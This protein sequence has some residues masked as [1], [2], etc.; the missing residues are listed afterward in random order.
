MTEL[1]TVRHASELALT[2]TVV[3]GVDG[4]RRNAAAVAWAVD[5]A[6]SS[7]APLLL[8][9]D[10]RGSGQESAARATVDRGVAL[11]ARIDPDLTPQ[12]GLTDLG[13]SAGLVH[14][15][16]THSGPGMIVVGRRGAG[17]FTRL[18]LGSTARNL[19][20]EPGPPTIVVPTGWASGSVPA[21]A[22]VV[23]DVTPPGEGQD[24]QGSSLST[25][26]QEAV[27]ERALALALTRARRLGR[28]VVAVRAWAVD[29]DVAMEGRAIGEVWGE[30]AT[31]AEEQLE[32]VLAPWRTA[33]PDVEVVGLTTD[34]HPVAVLL[35]Q[36]EG[37][38]LV[39]L[40]RGWRG[41]AVVEYA[42]CPVAVV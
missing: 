30:H 40:P 22:P 36:A 26:E 34:R 15:A 21:T 23:V 33:Y 5:E 35:D 10:R 18:K 42:T 13:A 12:T 25:L 11:V 4:S 9:H 16:R 39:I 37:A 1:A 20:H 31:R 17:G 29:A 3:V 14:A 32:R 28:P 41:C 19:V 38:E 8:V 2:T 27:H 6:G 7:G 24:H